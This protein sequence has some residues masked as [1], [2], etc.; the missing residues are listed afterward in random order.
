MEELDGMGD[1]LHQGGPRQS[2]QLRRF[3]NLSAMMPGAIPLPK[4][5]PLAKPAALGGGFISRPRYSFGG[6]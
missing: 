6:P 1:F 4:E 2:V 5:T 3:S